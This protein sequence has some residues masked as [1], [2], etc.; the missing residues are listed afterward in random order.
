[1]VWLMFQ[2]YVKEV[3]VKEVKAAVIINAFVRIK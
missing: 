3:K 1:M 2:M